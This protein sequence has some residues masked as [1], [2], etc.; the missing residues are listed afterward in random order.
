MRSLP[1]SLLAA[2]LAC[3]SGG[4]AGTTTGTGTNTT[5]TTTGSSTTGG[6]ACLATVCT[7]ATDCAS[8]CGR[9]YGCGLPFT[10]T[11]CGLNQ[12]LC[13]LGTDCCSGYCALLANGLDSVCANMP[14]GT[15]GSSTATTTSTGSSTSGAATTTGATTSGSTSS[16]TSSSGGAPTLAFQWTFGASQSCELASAAWVSLS[17]NGQAPKVVPCRDPSGLEGA[18]V[19]ASSVA[20][21][22]VSYSAIAY[23]GLLNAQLG[24]ATGQV[25][26]PVAGTAAVPLTVPLASAQTS[27]LELAW[28][29]GGQTLAQAGVTQLQLQVTDPHNPALDVSALLDGGGN[30]F[31]LPGY[32]SG[33]YPVALTGTGAATYSG[34]AAVSANGVT[35]AL[36]LVDL[37]AG[38]ALGDAGALVLQLATAFGGQSCAA[39]GIDTIAA[40]L[41]KAN[42]TALAPA[43]LVACADAG[44]SLTFAGVA[45]P[46]TAFLWLEGLAGTQVQLLAN[47]QVALFPAVS[48]T[49]TVIAEPA[50]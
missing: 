12:T 22:L 9:G 36:L 33:L 39:A 43:A 16:G 45:A 34:T 13:A 50:P 32:G 21:T 38:T 24:Q 41:V 35:P 30:G 37:P 44:A 46:A 26:A 18:R 31:T 29:F 27:S 25:L 23:D 1:L 15:T 49:Y 14:A 17:L 48:A 19:D 11:C 4:G 47:P 40:Q 10:D 5:G 6:P 7:S 20:G 28:T 2:C 3:S 8:A 42:G